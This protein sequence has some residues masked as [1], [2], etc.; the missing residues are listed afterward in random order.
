[1][2]R[3]TTA[4]IPCIIRAKHDKNDVPLGSHQCLVAAR[5]VVGEMAVVAQCAVWGSVTGGGWLE[6]DDDDG[7]VFYVL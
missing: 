7:D 2:F 1:M 6:W 5:R 4:D 3:T